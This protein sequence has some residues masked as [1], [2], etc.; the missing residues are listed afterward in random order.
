MGSDSAPVIR[1]VPETLRFVRYSADDVARVTRVAAHDAGLPADVP[2]TLEL[3]EV[4]G[5]P[6]TGTAADLVDGS[7]SLWVSGGTLED[8]KRPRELDED[9]ARAEIGIALLRVLDRSGPFFGAPV[10]AELPDAARVVWDTYAEGRLARRG[11]VVRRPRRH[12]MF[13][14]YC[15]FTDATDA[16]FDRVWGADALDWAEVQR[17]VADLDALDPRPTP[18][19]A[20][21]R[22][23]TLRMPIGDRGR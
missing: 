21:I 18:T 3:D 4:L 6:L 17:I 16:A 2:V 5:T 1:V 13:R 14:L 12:Y 9:K 20:P 11:V 8:Q 10:D 7:A 15:G 22:R 23:A 19:R